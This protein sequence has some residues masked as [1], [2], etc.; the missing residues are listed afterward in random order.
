MHMAGEDW[1][2]FHPRRGQYF[3]LDKNVGNLVRHVVFRA[4]HQKE[5]G[6]S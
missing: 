4:L 5:K 1:F 3:I 6:F 2:P